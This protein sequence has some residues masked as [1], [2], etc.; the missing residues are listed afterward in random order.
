[1]APLSV[2]RVGAC[3]GLCNGDRGR[4]AFEDLKF[5]FCIEIGR[6]LFHAG[7]VWKGIVIELVAPVALSGDGSSIVCRDSAQGLRVV[8][9]AARIVRGRGISGVGDALSSRRRRRRIVE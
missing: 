3:R 7:C 5:H 6:G 4:G 1:M 8:G 9:D 2:S